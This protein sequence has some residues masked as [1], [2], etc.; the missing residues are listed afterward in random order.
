MTQVDIKPVLKR[1]R[2]NIQFKMKLGAGYLAGWGFF[3]FI[4]HA[5]YETRCS[6]SLDV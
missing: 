3:S 1:Q 4:S 6:P 5:W 2:Y